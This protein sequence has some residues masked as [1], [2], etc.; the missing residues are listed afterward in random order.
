PGGS[1]NRSGSYAEQDK[2][3]ALY[4]KDDYKVSSKLTLNLGLRVEHES[5]IT[6]R[7]NRAV[8]GFAAG[9]NN[10]IE[11]AALANYTRSPIAEL[12]V[13][14]FQVNGGLTF[15]G[16]GGNPRDYWDAPF[17]TWM[18]RFGVAYQAR[19]N[20]VLRAGYGIF[21]A[22]IG[23]NRTNTNL[24]GFSRSTT[25]QPSADNGLNFIASLDNPFP[26]GLLEPLAAAG[27]LETNLN[28]GVSFFAGRRKQPYAQRWSLGFQRQF[29][30]GYVL[31][32]SYVG[33]R[34]TN[35]QASRNINA[36]PAQYLSTSPVRDQTTISFLT[37][38]STSPFFGLNPNYT[39]ATIQRQQLLRPYPH[40]GDI[41]FDDSVGYSWYHSWQSR[42]EKRFSQGYTLQIS[43]TWSKTMDAV[44][45]LN[46]SDPMPYETLSDLDRV[47]RTTGSGIWEL[48]FGRGRKFGGQWNKPLD[49]I[50]GGWQLNG[51]Y[52]RQSGAPIGF[53]QALFVGDSSTI[54]LPSDQRN[55]D[56][57]FN[58][59][60]FMRTSAQALANNIRSAPLRYS[61]IR[62]DSQRRLDLS[63]IKTFAVTERFKMKFRA[64]TFNTFN[65]VVLRGPNTDPYNSSFGIV[66]AQEPPRSWQFSLT[67]SF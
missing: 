12:S 55:A 22:S 14:Q 21:Y 30:T 35:I 47:L 60:V 33:N 13:A 41:T 66:T 32:S 57:W 58:T 5:A 2:Y 34:G 24:A 20:T 19:K 25:I 8:R 59:P 23:I 11:A 26:A 44:S 10:P 48:P 67:L 46:A 65:E 62:L 52:Q 63:L 36:T 37:A 49:F 53:G 6:E 7:Y 31:E 45:F 64:E 61:N 38:N 42:L 28:Q 15:A 54:T 29:W 3:F 4:F 9:A 51:V 43:H 39:S 18:P 1:M 17:L 40:F 16:V 27:G 56:R 50:A